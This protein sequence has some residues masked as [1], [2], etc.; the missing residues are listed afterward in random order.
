M[1]DMKLKLVPNPIPP[2][3]HGKNLRSILPT[4]DWDL[5]RSDC[6][7]KAE[8][9]CEICHGKGRAHPVE[10]HEEWELD[11]KKKIQKLVALQALCPNCHLVKHIGRAAKTGKFERAFKHF[12]KVNKLNALA[13]EQA[14]RDILN[15]QLDLLGISFK[16]DIEFAKQ[17]LLELWDQKVEIL[18]AFPIQHK[19]GD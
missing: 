7:I 2:E 13:G 11:Y 1:I 12:C 9:L 10:C 18:T 4:E 16:I 6:Y 14:L 17:R 15:S 3:S 19:K 5:L 8:Y